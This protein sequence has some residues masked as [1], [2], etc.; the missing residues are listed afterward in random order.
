MESG[1][2]SLRGIYIECGS[3]TPTDAMIK[4]CTVGK[5]KV[6]FL[7]IDGSIANDSLGGGALQII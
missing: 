4:C 3:I 6:G 7:L 5:D 1:N 2:F